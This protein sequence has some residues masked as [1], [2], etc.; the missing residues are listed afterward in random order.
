M[1]GNIGNV[2][3]SHLIKGGQVGIPFSDLKVHLS[4]WETGTDVGVEDVVRRGFE[5]GVGGG[6]E[7]EFS[8]ETMTQVKVV[9]LTL[10][11]IEI[12]TK[13]VGRQR[14]DAIASEGAQ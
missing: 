10:G 3:G 5:I 7:G 4:R 8:I 11:T 1:V 12:S 9:D 14:L 6:D 2:E 13:V